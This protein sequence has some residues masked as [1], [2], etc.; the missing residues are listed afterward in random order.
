M[1]NAIPQADRRV[2]KHGE[3]FSLSDASG[4]FP[5]V[6]D[7]PAG[8]YYLGTRFVSLWVLELGEDRPLVLSSSIT[9]DNTRLVAHFTT[10]HASG[11]LG[12]VSLERT[13]WL[14]RGGLFDRIELRNHG[15]EAAAVSVGLRFGADFADLFEI[16][17]TRRDRRGETLE[18][19]LEPGAVT[20]AYEGLD[21]VLR[22]SRLAFEPRPTSLAVDRARFELN[23]D[24]RGEAVIVAAVEC[25]VGTGPPSGPAP[26]RVVAATR[27]AEP[28]SESAGCRIETSH[29]EF[30][31]WLARSR[32]DLEMLTT[33]TPEGPYPYAG[34]P[35][36]STPFG[37]DGIWTA[38]ACLTINPGL[39]RGVLAHLAATQARDVIPEQDAQPGK[40]C[41]EE[42]A[43]EMAALGEVPFGRYYGS[44]DATPLFV[45]LA[46]AY[47]ERTGD[48]PFVA[49][50]WPNIERALGWIDTFGDADGDGFVEYS[51]QC[52]GGLVHQG[53]K[54]SGDSISHADGRLADG[55]VALCEV[56][57]YVYAARRAAAVLASKLG[58]AETAGELSRQARALR[59]RF[60]EAFWCESLSTYALALDGDKRPCEVRAS[61]AG[62]CL[63]T[64]I[65]SPS[66][67][68]RVARTLLC[69]DSFS[70]WGIRT[71]SSKEARYN[72]L[73]YHNGTVWPHD[74][75]II[76]AGFGRYRLRGA[77]LRVLSGLLDAARSAGTW[78]LPEL[79][80]GFARRPGEGF[81]P[82][83]VACAP[84][85]WAAAAVELL[86]QAC[87]GLEI[88][89]PRNRVCFVRPRLPRYI[90]SIR[91]SN[92]KLQDGSIDLLIERRADQVGVHVL[93]RMGSI[94]IVVIE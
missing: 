4:D 39:A 18:P 59:E 86:L 83:P 7:G 72:P 54:D 25:T 66:R 49:G 22:R 61:N 14:W 27:V 91:M 89:A 32:A 8:L 84:Q 3:A 73:S 6:A 23:L 21:G 41:H 56:Q 48:L 19:A 35:W 75:A 63:Y 76:A 42:R 51:R 40:I 13:Q 1:E 45:V 60:E 46:G 2:L 58:D 9:E 43:G 92:L 94:D 33:D 71:L 67:A 26:N 12:S 64:G 28:A 52:P 24:P 80:C 81:V 17:G 11:D 87:L 16:R 62:H 78:R 69:D 68:R 53:W 38:L 55:P 70:G 29:P 31:R 93:G 5:P 10:R 57:G 15:R 82:Y 79:F 77:A 65:A 37:R 36:F 50:I 44:V 34:I 74:N 20:L 47:Y 85:A 30:H 88:R 90:D